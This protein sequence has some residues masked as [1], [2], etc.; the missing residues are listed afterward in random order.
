MIDGFTTTCK[1]STR[2]A[3][4]KARMVVAPPPT[5]TSLPWA[6]SFARSRT[7]AA[8]SST[9]WKVAT[10]ATMTARA[11]DPMLVVRRCMVPPEAVA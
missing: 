1:V 6:A 5:R 9:K 3:S 2:S 10:P 7:L 8:S 11:A 4:R